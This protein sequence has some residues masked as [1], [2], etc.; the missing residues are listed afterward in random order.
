MI[1]PR[2]CK[3][4]GDIGKDSVRDKMTASV[5]EALEQLTCELGGR[6][7]HWIRQYFENENTQNCSKLDG[8][9]AQI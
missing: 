5:L 9:W 2:H 3:L 6:V 8:R 4:V 1:E 7:E